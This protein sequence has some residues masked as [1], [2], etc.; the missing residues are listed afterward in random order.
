MQQRR[1]YPIKFAAGEPICMF[2][3]IAR[4]YLEALKPEL[5]E[6]VED[7]ILLQEYLAWAEGREVFIEQLKSHSRSGFERHYSRGMTH[8][9]PRFHG[10]QTRMA[11]RGFAKKG[12]SG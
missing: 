1:D 7:P 3:P 8:G 12:T 6:M 11:L 2:F 10:H 9:S 4:G 5:K